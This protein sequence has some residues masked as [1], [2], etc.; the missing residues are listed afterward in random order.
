MG[1]RRWGTELRA[2]LSSGYRLVRF[3]VSSLLSLS[4]PTLAFAEW[5]AVEVVKT[6]KV[7]GKTG[8]ELYASIGERGPRV[9]DGRRVIAHTNFKL[10]WTRQ[11]ENQNGSCVL[12]SAVPKLT[13]TYM[14]P[15]AATRLPSPTKENWERFIAGVDAH[16]RV[17][18]RMIKDLVHRIE[19]A[20]V[21]LTVADDPECKKIRIELTRRLKAL[22]E[23][24]QKAN[25]D[26]DRAEL[27]D[28]GN[29]HQLILALVNGG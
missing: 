7:S 20:S 13:V 19:A 10:A 8:P 26:F 1:F 14:L 11:Y 24:H 29:I 25:S 4:L 23:A 22:S 27:S 3:A 2:K 5:Q 6:Y 18:G 9:E 12:V 28:G 16:E 21:G 17:H 15:K